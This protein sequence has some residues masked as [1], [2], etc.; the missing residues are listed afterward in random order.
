MTDLTAAIAALERER[1]ACAEK[2][3]AVERAVEGLRALVGDPPKAKRAASQKSNSK[4][5]VTGQ[6]VG[7]W[8]PRVMACEALGIKGPYLSE[9][10][11]KLGLREG[12]HFKRLG[13]SARAGEAWN[14]AAVRKV[15]DKIQ[16]RRLVRIDAPNN[17]R[18]NGGDPRSDVRPGPTKTEESK[19]GPRKSKTM[20]A[21]VLSLY[22]EGKTFQ[23]IATKLAEKSKLDPA[24]M[25]RI[26]R[27]VIEAD[28]DGPVVGGEK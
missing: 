8:V 12:L 16:P 1:S 26:V 6:N 11:T 19:A 13:D 10:K 22:A 24:S 28:A 15:W 14:V 21:E 4:R 18:S 7:G 2:L 27:K 9:L 3:A 17:Q 20:R 23:D 5:A 25:G